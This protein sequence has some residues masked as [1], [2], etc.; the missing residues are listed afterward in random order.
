M[1]V[2]P[3]PLGAVLRQP[4]RTCP[5]HE[6][7]IRAESRTAELPSRITGGPNLYSALMN[8]PGKRDSRMK[9]HPVS[10]TAITLRKQGDYDQALLREK[11]D[12]FRATG[13]SQMPEG[14]E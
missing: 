7:G 12:E 8:N 10:P 9:L 4:T 13:K 14:F 1:M 6:M 3:L 11:I 2:L 5:Y